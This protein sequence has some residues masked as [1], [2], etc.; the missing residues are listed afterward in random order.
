MGFRSGREVP[1]DIDDQVRRRLR[2]Q[3]HLTTITNLDDHRIRNR[4]TSHI[5]QIRRRRTRRTT[6]IHRHKTSSL[7]IRHR[8]VQH[9]RSRITTNP[10]TTHHR[11]H[12]HRPSTTH[13]NPIE[14]PI[15]R[16]QIRP[17]LQQPSRHQRRQ[18][19][20]HREV[21]GDVD[22]QVR[23]RLREQTHLTTITNLDDHRIRNRRTS[24]IVQIRRRRT[25]RTTRIHRHKTSSL[26]IRHRHVQ[27]HRSRITTNPTTTNHRQHRH[28]PSTTHTNPIEL[29]INRRQIR[30]RLQQPSR[31][32]RRQTRPHR[33]VPGD[34]DDQ[35]RRRL[36]EQTHLTTITNLDDHRIRNRRTS[37]IVQIRRRRTRRT[38][39]IHRHKTSSLRIRHR[40]VQ[41]H[42]S[43]ITTNPTTTHHRQHRHRPS[44]THT[45]PIELPINRRQIRPRLQQPSRHQR[46]HRR[47]SEDHT[48]RS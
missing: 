3:T 26:R 30:P 42:R 14:L 47:P 25:R 7:R 31:H 10:T 24:H 21:P 15:N 23:R 22:D 41:H 19:R 32:Q 17:R 29:P 11:Q 38:T 9:H 28:R 1:G 44:T 34:I 33:E 48:C 43:R 36:R 5:V 45:N 6:R 2:E 39:R 4:R 40:H 27:H 20:P 18:T 16:R 8:H 35:V 13:T 37:H 12:R 46:L